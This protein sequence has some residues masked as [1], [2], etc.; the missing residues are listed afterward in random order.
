M[1][2]QNAVHHLFVG[3]R[4]IS[5]LFGPDP[6]AAQANALD[7]AGNILHSHQIT[8]GK[9]PVKKDNKRSDQVFQAFP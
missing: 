3:H 2:I 1:I 6:C 5:L 8:L 7:I 9:R 4:D